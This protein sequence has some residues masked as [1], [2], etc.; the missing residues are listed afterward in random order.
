MA[1]AVRVSLGFLALALAAGAFA[2][3]QIST[4]DPWG[5]LGRMAR[6]LAPPDFTATDRIA[7]ALAQTAAFAIIGVAL[8]AAAGFALSLLFHNPVVRA[9]C[10]VIRAIHELFWALIFLQMFG[11]SPL[12][13][14]LAVAIPYAG[15]FAKVYSEILDEADARPASMVAPG[16]GRVALFF[17]ARLP[18]S[19]P[20]LGSYTLYRL[21]CGL[22]SSAVLGFVG[23]PTLGFHLETAFK[24][25]QYAEVW[26]LL[27]LFYLMIATI[28]WWMRPR[29]AP[30]WLLAA[31]FVLPVGNAISLDNVVRFFTS[32]IVPQPLRGASWLDPAAQG[33]FVKWLGHMFNLEILGGIVN[34]LL[35]SQIA[36]VASGLLA[37]GLFPLISRHFHGRLGATAGHVFLVVMRSTPEYVLAFIGL[38]LWG[39]SMLPAA[40]ALALHNG[41]LIGHLMGRHVDTLG[42]RPDAPKG[43]NLYA[44][45]ILPRSY[46]Q[47]LAFLF[48]RWEWIVRETAIFGILGIRTLGFFVD[49]A[50]AELRFDRAMVLIGIVVLLNLGVDA[51]SR[52]IRAHLRLTTTPSAA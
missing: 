13:G 18:D 12:T 3:F 43:L 19:L 52:F 2:D 44:Y 40:V 48:Y 42:L 27:I 34:T 9:V 46:G 37:L 28:R 8:G 36:L 20:H 1:P 5:E 41:A 50:I 39:P 33:A 21:E 4:S 38:L 35:L 30:F 7:L 16:A 14:I 32:D 45:E 25:G 31:P 47:F 26:A 49:S 11:L 6:G 24:Q 23:V 15:I 51:L 29:L 10:V 22:R 17:F